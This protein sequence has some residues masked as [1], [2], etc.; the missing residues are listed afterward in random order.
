M[1]KSLNVYIDYDEEVNDDDDLE[2]IYGDDI[3]A[4]KGDDSDIP[5]MIPIASSPFQLKR[6][7]KICCQKLQYLQEM[8]FQFNLNKRLCCN[9]VEELQFKYST[10]HS[11][12]NCGSFHLILSFTID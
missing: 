8:L 7:V 2:S 4:Q 9:E 10:S 5:A 1:K 6:K 3:V 11:L 12:K